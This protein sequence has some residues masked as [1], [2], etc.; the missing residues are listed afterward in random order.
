MLKAIVLGRVCYDFNLIVDNTPQ[1]GATYEFFEK[2]GC[3][4]GAAANIAYCLAKWGISTAFAGVLGN[5]VYGTRV[6]K[7]FDKVN[8]D[9]R[10]IEQS[11]DN[12]T[13]LC[14][15]VI[16][17]A[18]KTHTDYYASDKY[19]HI[20]GSQAFVGPKG[21]MPWD[22]DHYLD[23]SNGYIKSGTDTY[24]LYH[25][26]NIIKSSNSN[27]A[28]V[29]FYERIGSAAP[30]YTVTVTSDTEGCT[31]SA[32]KASYEEGE[33]VTL[34]YEADA[35][36]TFTAWVEEYEDVE[37]VDNKF[38]MPEHDVTISATF[39]EKTQYGI[40]IT[41]NDAATLHATYKGQ[42]ISQAP[43]DLVIDL[44]YD[45][46]Q[47][48]Y[49][50]DHWKVSCGTDNIEV[51]NNQFIMPA[52]AVTV[53]AVFSELT[54]HTVTIATVEGGTISV[55]ANEGPISTGSS[56][57]PGTTLTFGN[58]PTKNSYDQALFKLDY[59]V[60]T[61]E[62][63]SP[64]HLDAGVNT[65]TMPNCNLTVS[66]V[67]A[68]LYF[69]T[70]SSNYPNN[71]T[72]WAGPNNM[73]LRQVGGQYLHGVA[74]GEY[75]FINAEDIEGYRKTVTWSDSQGQHETIAYPGGD[76]RPCFV[77][78]ADNNVV[79]NV[80]YAV[81]QK[82][83][84]ALD[85]NTEGGSI[86]VSPSEPVAGGTLV[87]IYIGTPN[88]HFSFNASALSV[89]Y[90]EGQSS[91]AVTTVTE[92]YYYQFSM[93]EDNVTV[94]A[95]FTEDES[96]A[97]NI[98]KPESCD[99]DVT[100]QTNGQN[101]TTG[102]VYCG[103]KVYLSNLAI[104]S[105]YSFDG[106]NVTYKDS[107]GNDQPVEVTEQS[108]QTYFVM[109]HGNVTLTAD[110]TELEGRTVTIVQTTGGTITVNGNNSGTFQAF[111]NDV[112]TMNYSDL[113]EGFVFDRWIITTNTNTYQTTDN[114][115]YMLDEDLSIQ[116]QF[117]RES[118]VN[119]GSSAG[120]DI[121]INLQMAATDY[122]K[123]RSQFI[124]NANDLQD[125]YDANITD[126]TFF[127]QNTSSY[128][129]TATWNVYLKEV[130]ET[131]FASDAYVDVTEMTKVYAGT[132]TIS[133]YKMKIH[134]DDSFAYT[135]KNLMVSLVQN[136]ANGDPYI[137]DGWYGVYTQNSHVAYGGYIYTEG[138]GYSYSTNFLPKTKF[139]YKPSENPTTRYEITVNEVE[140][141]T[142]SASRNLAAAGT[143]ITLTQ[144]TSD[145]YTF[146]SWD[147]TSELGDVTV[148]ENNQFTM[149]AANVTVSANLTLKQH[150]FVT[151]DEEITNGELSLYPESEIGY[152]QNEQ[153]RISVYPNEGYKLDE[154][155]GVK[156]WNATEENP[157]V[158]T[159]PT[160]EW[161]SYSIE[162]PAYNIVISARFTELTAYTIT[163]HVNGVVTEE[164][165]YENERIYPSTPTA[166]AGTSFIGWAT[167]DIATYIETEPT[168]FQ[169]G[170][171]PTEDL[172][173]Y[174]VFRYADQSKWTP[175]Y[176]ESSLSTDGSDRVIFAYYNSGNPTI[177]TS[178]N[179][180]N[181]ASAT[182]EMSGSEI[183]SIP[184]NTTILKPVNANGTWKF[185]FDYNGSE[186]TLADWEGNNL[187]PQGL[188]GYE[189]SDT[190]YFYYGNVYN[191]VSYKYVGLE[192]W[193]NS[194]DM[195][196]YSMAASLY[197]EVKPQGGLDAYFTEV[198]SVSGDES[199]NEDKEVRNLL[200]NEGA[201]Y[202]VNGAKLTVSGF[203]KNVENI[204][205]NFVVTDGG[206]LIHNNAGTVATFEKNIIGYN[207]K[208]SDGWY[209]IANPTANTTVNLSG[210]NSYDLYTFNPAAAAE[211]H[212]E[213]YI[214]EV[215][216][217]EENIAISRETGYL[218]ANAT[219]FT[220][221][222]EGELIPSGED[223]TIDLVYYDGGEP[224]REFPGFNLIGNPFSCT[225][226]ISGDFD[227]YKLVNGSEVQIST[228]YTV[229][230]CEAF[231]ME[232]TEVGETVTLS[233]TAPTE[234]SRIM[235]IVVNSDRGETLDRA[236]LHLE[237]MRNSHKFMMNPDRT[238]I[239]FAK[240]G[241]R[242][243]SVSRGD[244]TEIPM[245]F[246]ADHKG[247]YTISFNTE[248]FEEEYLHLIDVISGDNIDLLV[249][250]SYTF[251]ADADEYA[252]RFRIVFGT[253]DINDNP[254][255]SSAPF[256]YI[257]NGNL[258]INNVEGTASMQIVD[259]LGRIVRTETV[260][261]SYNRPHNL[262]AGAY[263][264]TLD[265]RAQR[266]VIE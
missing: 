81:I 191:T 92:G 228:D 20:Y 243:A 140:G 255:T 49:V 197:K 35:F 211:W 145:D 62:G 65:Y 85:Y 40:T 88:L 59:Y 33:T 2:Q 25:D 239:S 130:D 5:D 190:W 23:L 202:T 39:T 172:N 164:T 238:N 256:V 110:V 118:T 90:N 123:T 249:T 232:A 28:Y 128:S 203:T 224:G 51:N 94:H 196:D 189:G 15:H 227:M 84:I 154:E 67:F 207:S 60:V 257:S 43:Q 174:A 46:L 166:P 171:Y 73:N 151:L 210:G 32:D 213:Q 182:G 223:Q 219:N 98:V 100:Y 61:E 199:M 229:A 233:T 54:A 258:V 253:T 177:M 83:N 78:P 135:D 96:Y 266:I 42:A 68:P 106:W 245:N 38:T 27:N 155:Y 184:A 16:N 244:E 105:G 120:Y 160:P 44:S 147:V 79:V 117:L 17:K 69:P 48:G 34:S 260:S 9:Q 66:A 119:D 91:V 31:A 152:M 161:G 139:S 261:G 138:G 131:E 250:P 206:Q 150:Y 153:V 209:F 10:Y 263:V 165:V 30:T 72:L 176:D 29:Y 201:S 218:Y 168:L 221:K 41:P 4:G 47:S 3:G 225:A 183:V 112:I 200:I 142:L 169:T 216:I 217:P 231:F 26:G 158:I 132:L 141:T 193:D 194:F 102:N 265:G 248:N 149:P 74:A 240:N 195:V 220:L 126:M 19:L 56:V 22:L 186:T 115:F 185:Y 214:D 181:F 97:V 50:F 234:K 82:Y 104:S 134:F 7:E 137:W 58:T 208:G 111:Q 252:S 101:T 18:N 222:F 254:A 93:P 262:K 86:T 251:E 63:S 109:P 113:L 89:T 215:Q 198:L 247:S 76:S 77:M 180:W 157:E 187:F 188:Y 236:I 212:N 14:F 45:N 148:D 159:L 12:D 124:I 204:A 156:Y 57:Y 13:P 162:M 108:G 114:W 136:E 53:S 264:I 178:C 259:M 237:G 80:Q 121:P 8:I 71:V 242:F 144:E 99:F 55:S 129:F 125:M 230:P 170:D 163:Y 192:T 133:D 205:A 87:H 173:L 241:E 24:H 146:N 143:V 175:V 246:T 122:A 179:G 36:H 64:Q 6:R 116:A 226:Y 11:Y 167:S 103:Y 1:E 235:P 37:I 70:I 21:S 127:V 95:E 52:G 75:V 107:E